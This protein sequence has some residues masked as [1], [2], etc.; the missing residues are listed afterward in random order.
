MGN[1]GEN[2]YCK[3]K[4]AKSRRK[5]SKKLK[6][7][8]KLKNSQLHLIESGNQTLDPDNSGEEDLVEQDTQQEM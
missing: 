6:K 3:R 7:I 1:P 8:D 4:K 5:N 2:N